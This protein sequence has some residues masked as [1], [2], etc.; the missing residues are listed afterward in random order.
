MTE[1]SEH[2]LWRFGLSMGADGVRNAQRGARLTGV[3]RDDVST[4]PAERIDGLDVWASIV[5]E[6]ELAAAPIVRHKQESS[7]LD[8]G[9]V[10]DSSGSR[11]FS[12]H[13]VALPSP[14]GSQA[15]PLLVIG[16][17]RQD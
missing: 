2:G 15:A 10:A 7:L 6:G 17:M 11:C 3:L 14:K 16:P 5:G 13:V 8:N 1:T 4:V 12:V 9:D